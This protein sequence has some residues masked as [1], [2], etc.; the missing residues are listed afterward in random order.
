M[1]IDRLVRKSR[2]YRRFREGYRVSKKILLD[3][4]E[5]GRLSPS[6]RNQQALKFYLSNTGAANNLIFPALRWAGALKDWNG[7]CPGERPAAYILILGDTKI[8]RDFGPD[9]GIA[10]QSMLLGAVERGLGGCM[11]GNIDRGMLREA[12]NVP[13]HLEILLVVAI[14]K[15]HEK[16]ILE[17]VK[18]SGGTAYYR[19]GS[20]AHHVPKRRL[21]DIVIR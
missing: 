17:P 9:H 21:R 12:V 4:A 14:G 13:A 10:A 20:G 5:L 6:M 18:D 1:K 8:S 19:D 2:S 3:L 16:I 15:P 7:P 11:I